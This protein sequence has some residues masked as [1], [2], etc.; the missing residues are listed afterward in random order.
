MRTFAYNNI[1]FYVQRKNSNHLGLSGQVLEGVAANLSAYVIEESQVEPATAGAEA[2]LKLFQSYAD[3]RVNTFKAESEKYKKEADDWKAKAEKSN[4]P[5]PAPSAG[6]QGNAE[7]NAII[8]KLNTLQ[9]SFAE[10]QKGK[11][12]ES[13]KEHFVRLMKEKNIPESYYSHSLV[14]RDFADT[15]EVETLVN[16]V[17]EG[18]GKQEQEL[19]ARGFSYSKAPDTPDDPQKEEEAIANLIE[20]ETEKLTTSNK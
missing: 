18:F 17:T 16:A 1:V 13:L 19:S 20:Q 8:E 3:N 5:T 6:N 7:M 10:F 4:E 12:A 15:S 9:N 11:T 2:M 14:G